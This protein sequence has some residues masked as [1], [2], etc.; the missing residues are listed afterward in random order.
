MLQHR[1]NIYNNTTTTANRAEF[2]GHASSPPL[3]PLPT[4]SDWI[5]DTGATIHMT[6]HL[7]WFRTYTPNKTPIRL[8]DSSIIYSAGFGDVE[9]E[10]VRRNGKPGRRLVFQCVLHVPD[11]CCNLFSV[12]YL[13]TWA[14]PAIGSVSQFGNYYELQSLLASAD[15]PA[16]YWP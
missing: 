5:A 9:F 8:A 14:I 1:N 7:H 6:P 10:P 12:L 2:A 13:W 11:L 16:L 15:D 4:G 3:S